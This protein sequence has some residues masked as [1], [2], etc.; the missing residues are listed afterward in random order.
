MSKATPV[1]HRCHVV[2]AVPRCRQNGLMARDAAAPAPTASADWLPL[3]VERLVQQFQPLRII[4]FGSHARGDARPDSDLDLLVVLPHLGDK[5]HAMVEMLR[6]LGDL[7]VATD[8]IPTDPNEI[9]RRGNMIGTVLRPALREG[10]V[11]YERGA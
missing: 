5:R 8:V 11:L 2:A 7:P 6:T 10:R 1:P 3:V 4:L 9:E